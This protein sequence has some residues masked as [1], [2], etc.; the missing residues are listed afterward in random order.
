MIL[1]WAGSFGFLTCRNPPALQPTTGRRTFDFV[2]VILR[3]SDISRMAMNDFTGWFHQRVAPTSC[4]GDE[5]PVSALDTISKRAPTVSNVSSSVGNRQDHCKTGEA[6]QEV[7]KE[8]LQL[9]V[10]LL[11]D[12]LSDSDATPPPVA[13]QG[14]ATPLSG[15][16]LQFPVC[17]R[18]VATTPHQR[19]LSHP[20]TDPIAIISALSQVIWTSE[21][22]SRSRGV[23]HLR[24]SRYTLTLS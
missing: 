15:L 19:A 4:E 6:P 14:V 13:L 22:L 8:P 3:H 24:V 17:G 11:L 7:W 5:E 1:V 10:A 9:W 18:G 16:F 20:I 12:K 21:A 23:L 2:L